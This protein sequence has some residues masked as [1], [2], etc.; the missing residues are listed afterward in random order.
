[1]VTYFV[2]EGSTK[3]RWFGDPPFALWPPR[4]QGLWKLVQICRFHTARSI[5]GT[6]VYFLWKM[7][8]ELPPQ[9]ALFGQQKNP[10]FFGQF[11][12]WAK[13]DRGQNEMPLGFPGID[14]AIIFNAFLCSLFSLT[15]TVQSW[16]QGGFSLLRMAILE[17]F[18]RMGTPYLNASPQ[19]T[20]RKV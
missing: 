5:L 19:K 20:V 10:F 17:T 12:F 18:F 11:F 4:F 3:T 9:K 15:P 8:L 16:S 6:H 14:I 1:M 2:F 13:K 7:Y